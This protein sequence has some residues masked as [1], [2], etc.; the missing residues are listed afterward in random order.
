DSCVKLSRD[1]RYVLPTGLNSRN[2]TLRSTRVY[3]VATGQPAGPPLEAGGIILDAAFSPN[4]RQVATLVA[5]A[6]P[7]ERF[8]R[9]GGQA[10]QVQLWDWRTGKPMCNPVLTPSEP[11][12]LD[13][14]IDGRQLAVICAGGQL[15][16]IDPTTGQ[17]TR[18]WPAHRESLANNFYVHN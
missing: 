10:G 3:E 14:S 15:V 6:N 8:N 18:Q 12:G 7:K 5:L 16:V 1:G 11:R 4:D 9:L 2:C 17:I 13:Y